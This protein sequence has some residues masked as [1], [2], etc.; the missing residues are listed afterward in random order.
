M[1]FH[2][3]RI[4]TLECIL[5]SA[6]AA[7]SSCAG[8]TGPSAGF[9]AG[10]VSK[11]AHA[12]RESLDAGRYADAQSS[13]LALLQLVAKSGSRED[14]DEALDLLA[15]AQ[16]RNGD[17]SAAA[18]AQADQAVTRRRAASDPRAIARALHN[19]GRLQFLAGRFDD[20]VATLETAVTTIERIAPNDPLLADALDSLGLALVEVARYPD[21]DRQLHRSLEIKKNAYSGEDSHAARTWEL[22]SLTSQRAGQYALARPPLERAIAL[23][24]SQPNHPETG[25]TFGLLGDLLWLEGRPSAARDAYETCASITR[26]SLRANHPLVAICTRGL[27]NALVRIGD[28]AGALPVLENAKNTAENSLGRDHPDFSG[29]LN[30]L[31]VMYW[32]LSDFQKARVLYEEAL[33]IRERRLGP[34]HQD[35]ATIVYN[36]GLISRDLGDLVEAKRQLDRA[37][38]IWSHRFGANHPFVALAM[39]NLARTLRQHGREAEALPLQ[40]QVLAIRERVLGPNHPATA[41]ALN[42]LANTLLSL[43]RT[44]EAIAVSQRATAILELTDA[45]TPLD[46]AGALTT[47]GNVLAAAGDPSGARERYARA[48]ELT[49]RVLGREHPDGAELRVK[50]GSVA[51]QDG[52]PDVAFQ[53]ASLAEQS[54]RRFLQTTARYLPEREALRYGSS[55]PSGLNLLLSLSAGTDSADAGAAVDAIIKNRSLVLDLI[56]ARRITQSALD[57]TLSPLKNAWASARQRLANLAV[58]GPGNLSQSVYE[59]LVDD[60]RRE[61]E[62]AERALAERSAAF[63]AELGKQEIGLVEVRRTLPA[64]TALV[65]YVRYERSIDAKST[66]I[67]SKRSVT[68]YL[69]FVLPADS[70]SLKVV[71]LGPADLLEKEIAHWRT[72]ALIGPT[73]SIASPDA[74][75]TLR[76]AGEQVRH[77]IWDPLEAHVRG[78]RRILVVPDGALHLVNLAALPVDQSTYVIDRSPVIHYLTAERDIVQFAAAPSKTNQGLLAIGGP[79]FDEDS[80]TNRAAPATLP[81]VDRSATTRSACASFQSMHFD[82]LPATLGEV[83]EVV[84]LWGSAQNSSA[85]RVLTGAAATEGAFKLQARGTRVLHLATHGFFLGSECTDGI[86]KRAVGGIAASASNLNA[87]LSENPLLQSGLAFATANNHARAKADEEDGILTAEEVATLDLDGTEWAVLSACDT[88]LGEVQSGEGVFGLRRAFQIAGVRAV[89]M[90]LWPVDDEATRAWMTAL[91]RARLL[92]KMDTAESVHAASLKIL[93]ER[94]AKGLSTDPLYWGAFVAAGDWR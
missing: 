54:A 61:A 12:I 47:R 23:R 64:A 57:P 52:R 43:G 63:K 85:T 9:S 34:D 13:A 56:A 20:A 29:Y 40:R 53:E 18:L 67:G 7:F 3:S 46:Y 76:L 50:L 10:Q 79:L 1:R 74:R 2:R 49:E 93:H 68:S 8:C 65:S 55:R 87:A 66:I 35:V 41:T 19:L 21:A 71:P 80:S 39:A 77:R 72:A 25:A 62:R 48:L 78:A 89:I 33:A 31:A 38:A 6:L 88:G 69:A 27:G 51:Y 60:A 59:K 30:D 32:R 94:R 45:S 11:R 90:S 15:E 28:L 84:H 24:R 91:Y 82:P 92:E 42:D 75:R 14:A 36:L 22:L 16:W 44:S 86:G 83:Q 4:T 73:R 81:P 5:A 17:A 58:R 70:S 37:I 26:R